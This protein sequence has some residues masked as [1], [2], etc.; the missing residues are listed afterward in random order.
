M[1]LSRLK[2]LVATQ[3]VKKFTDRDNAKEAFNRNLGDYLSGHIRFKVLTYYGVG[4]IGKTSLL[5]ELQRLA[6]EMS[7]SEQKKLCCITVDFDSDSI[8]SAVDALYAFRQRWPGKCP[9]FE[10]ALAKY[11]AAQGK[12]LDQ[13]KRHVIRE[14]SLLFDLVEAG[15][16]FA[17]V[18]APAKL[19]KKLYSKGAEFIQRHGDLS[20]RFEEI[21]TLSEGQLAEWLPVLL[22]EEIQKWLNNTDNKLLLFVDGYERLLSKDRFKLGKLIGDEWLRES[23]G[24][25]ENGLYIICGRNYLSWE[26]LNPE[27]AVFIEQHVLGELASEDANTFL[28]GIPVEDGVIRQSIVSASHGVPLY[29][30]LCASIYILKKQAGEPVTEADFQGTEGR[31]I[32]RFLNY[33]DKEQAEAVRALSSIESFDKKLFGEI[34]KSLNIGIPVTL[35]DDFCSASYAE[36][37]KESNTL[38]KIH[39]IVRA[40]LRPNIAVDDLLTIVNIVFSEAQR[41]NSHQ[42]HARLVWLI[43]GLMPSLASGR[44][45]LDH[46]KLLG[47]F[48]FCA[49][50]A[51]VGFIDEIMEI[52]D[53][54]SMIPISACLDDLRLI[55]D[56]IRAYCLRRASRLNEATE[57]YLSI[58]GNEL[59]RLAPELR[60]RIR[61][62]AAHVSHL[63]GK[64]SHA[65]AEYQAIVR[66][67]AVTVSQSNTRTRHLARRQLGDLL[68]LEGGFTEALNLFEE[69]QE[70]E[71]ADQLWKLECRRFIGHVYRFNWMFR[72][73]VQ[74]Y[75][76]I[77]EQSKQCN[78]KGMYGKALVNL[79]EIYCITDPDRAI[80]TG[81]QAI[82]LCDACGN[83]IEVGKALTA[84]SLAAMRKGNIQDSQQY[85]SQ[86]EDVQTSTGYRSGLVF[87]E[88]ARS[89]ILFALGKDELLNTSLS[90]IE[91]LVEEL[92]VYQFLSR[93]AWSICGRGDIR[94]VASAYSWVDK[95]HTEDEI[96]KFSASLS[97]LRT[98]ACRQ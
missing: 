65:K 54:L 53:C 32:D 39:D 67:I 98:Q 33:L 10:F 11:W 48:V 4:G 20:Q 66:E 77:A 90:N 18:F 59:S 85:L 72:E 37:I 40:Y 51:D 29:L 92:G 86:A 61:Y 57:I 30:D 6:K 47:L 14:D 82:E 17:D 43:R 78:L 96:L 8:G 73:A 19:V 9:L 42:D 84:L 64:Y 16:S 81:E 60:L 50:L 94:T 87:V 1:A 69:C 12:S 74:F 75:S 83:R 3:A 31:V 2:A 93:E 80:E 15:S 27:W 13:I 68:M 45:A 70:T 22:G 62:N 49:D 28:M 63:L 95:S 76:E 44:V 34:T 71:D 91:A 36:Y 88:Y 5:R 56:A 52:G 41:S 46:E 23:I 26:D 7:G 24:A 58:S 89:C 38:A 79:T 97:Q 35:F 25:T 21:E 55:G